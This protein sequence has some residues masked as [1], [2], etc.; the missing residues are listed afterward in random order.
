MLRDF[1][2]LHGYRVDYFSDGHGAISALRRHPGL[3]H[4]VI[5]DIRM[6]PLDGMELLKIVTQE[7]PQLPVF[8]FTADSNE[9][10]KKAAL[11]LGAVSYLV[12]PFPLSE[13]AEA[14]QRRL[15]S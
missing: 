4:A 10:E 6:S 1:F 8:L 7:M 14:L 13:L 15:A 2:T 12:K 11:N 3:Y 9:A 5:S